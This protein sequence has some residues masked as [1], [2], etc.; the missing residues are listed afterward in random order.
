VEN[1]LLPDLPTVGD[2]VP[3]YEA[4][5]VAGI[6]APK[7]TPAEIVDRLNSEINA[8]LVDPKVKA[9]LADLGG[10]VLTLSPTDYGKLNAAEI[11]KWAK[12]V[13]FAG[14]KAE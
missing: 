13:K 6:A 12:V 10:T 5:A 9:R 2:F 3:G 4:S 1:R 11:E 8:A 14:I 7:R